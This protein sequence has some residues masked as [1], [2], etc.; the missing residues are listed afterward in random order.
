LDLT[1][2]GEHF[3]GALVPDGA[4]FGSESEGI[5]AGDVAFQV[6]TTAVEV[7]AFNSS[8]IETTRAVRFMAKA[9]PAASIPRILRAALGNL[10]AS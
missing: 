8:G 4:I 2:L 1:G 6:G 3:D 5:R 10:P 7:S 9:L